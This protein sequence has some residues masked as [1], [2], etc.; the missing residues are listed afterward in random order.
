MQLR[1]VRRQIRSKELT[2]VGTVIILLWLSYIPY[3]F[4]FPFGQQEGLKRLAKHLAESPEAVKEL[5]GIGGK[6]ERHLAR[7]LQLLVVVQL[8]KD[9]LVVLIGIGA[10][11]LIIK[12]KRVGRHIALGMC[13]FVLGYR[14][15]PEIRYFHSLRALSYKYFLLFQG[16]PG[17]LIRDCALVALT[18][19]ILVYLVRPSVGKKFTN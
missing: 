6:T 7:E 10:G 1:E 8:I 13:V 17:M 9:A 12:R 11:I 3:L 14:I 16:W 18:L 15:Y 4:A 2:I 19:V 5:V